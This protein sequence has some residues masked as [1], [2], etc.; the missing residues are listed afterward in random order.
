MLSP[1]QV[2][3]K[4]KCLVSENWDVV[5]R[6]GCELIFFVRWQIARAVLITF[7]PLYKDTHPLSICFT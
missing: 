7:F 5:T 6:F 4:I 3:L 1:A 2:I